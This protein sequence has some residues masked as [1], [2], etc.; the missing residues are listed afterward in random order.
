MYKPCVCVYFLVAWNNQLFRK[1][2]LYNYHTCIDRGRIKRYMVTYIFVTCDLQGSRCT[3]K[4]KWKNMHRR[5]EVSWIA[6]SLLDTDT[7]NLMA[8]SHHCLL[9]HT[10]LCV[11]PLPKA[12]TVWEMRER[13][14]E[15]W[16][17]MNS[18]TISCHVI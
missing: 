18:E 2:Q 7:I 10:L 15:Y 11:A 14:R 9:N 8:E 12:N 1:N 3:T 17:Y 5:G 4:S 16:W 6:R 13:E